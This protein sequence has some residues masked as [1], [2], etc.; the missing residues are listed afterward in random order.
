MTGFRSNNVLICN[1]EDDVRKFN[2]QFQHTVEASNLN[3]SLSFAPHSL[4]Y[5]EEIYKR[6]SSKSKTVNIESNE[7]TKASVYNENIDK[8]TTLKN[9]IIKNNECNYN[10]YVPSMDSDLYK[11]N[12]AYHK[13]KG[14]H[15]LLFEIPN[16]SSSCTVPT[17]SARMNP[18][19][20]FTREQRNTF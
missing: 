7:P 14:N 17:T 16:F 5:D 6:E 11:L 4:K 9:Q 18:F 3:L 12:V 20:N 1:L 10:T 13:Q 8:E 2:K 15:D 19:N